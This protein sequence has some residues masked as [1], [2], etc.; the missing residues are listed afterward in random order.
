MGVVAKYADLEIWS[1]SD[2]EGHYSLPLQKDEHEIV[3]SFLGYNDYSV[4]VRD[5]GEAV[6]LNITMQ[7]EAID[8]SEVAVTAKSEGQLKRE[9]PA[10]ITVL[11]AKKL[12]GRAVSL[13][14][15]V[16]Q[17][18]GVKVAQQ[19]GLGCSSNIFVQGLDGKRISIFVNNIPVG[20][21]DEFLIS[22][23]PVDLIERVEIY[24]GIVPA[25]LSSDGLGGAINIIMKKQASDYVEASYETGSYNTHK[26]ATQGRITFEKPGISLSAGAFYNYSDNNYTFNSP[27]NEG[28]V[29][30]RD[31][32]AYRAYNFNLG[33]GFSRLWFDNMDIGVSYGNVY[34]EVQGGL[35]N[36]QGNIQHAHYKSQ[37]W[38][39]TQSFSKKMSDG[40][41]SVGLNSLIGYSVFN[42][43]DTSH[44]R[45]NFDGT[46]YLSPSVQ[47]EVGYLPNDSRDV[48]S[49][50]NELLNISF[51][52]NERNT[53][54]L[55]SSFKHTN[56]TPQDELADSY[57]QYETSGY[58]SK[59][60]AVVSGLT[61][62]VKFMEGKL[63]N[64]TGAK[65][66][67]HRSE[68][69]PSSDHSAMQ[70]LIITTNENYNYGWNEAL[71]WK[72]LNDQLTFKASVQ[73]SVRIPVSDELFGDGVMIYPSPNLTPEKSLNF[74]V[75]ADW[76]VHSTGYPNL[77]IDLNAYYMKVEDMIKLMYSVMQMAYVNI[78]EVEIK[79]VEL[80]LK[81]EL[82]RW[83]SVSGNCSYNDARDVM[84]YT[85]GTTVPNPTKDK[86]VPNMP[87]LFGNAGVELHK[88]DI[89][90]K[91]T[92]TA[93][94][95]EAQFTEEYYYNWKISKNQTQVIPRSM[96]FDAGVRQAFMDNRLLL[97]FEAHNITGEEVWGQYQYPLPGRTF[98][99]KLKYTF[100]N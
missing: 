61:Y 92:A 24:K 91:K 8:L 10:S 22:S 97:S 89:L 53:L 45:Y 71:A 84:K 36:V 31:H 46:K 85:A 62:E 35:Q 57:A 83:C 100:T 1:V 32:D 63:T 77:R 39:S 58:E 49:D 41:L 13:D 12:E 7:V 47:G 70:T 48:Q 25:W 95:C 55:N 64:S 87:Y 52:V 79:G 50:V 17:A 3:F 86:R 78:G 14:N 96:V 66:F 75:G 73:Q 29:I 59:L 4:A 40:R 27:F 76:L 19:G 94:F 5:E 34:K 37:S 90:F 72:T 54:N 60:T 51:R 38:Q 44:Y 68:V 9:A 69:V 16:G 6:T 67:M 23:I 56:K 11:D 26:A 42:Q 2:V 20:S 98:H 81:S 33:A 65:M 21:S 93:L 82:A 88:K 80:E 30:T 99:I 43:I 15:M 18:A 74:N 28:L